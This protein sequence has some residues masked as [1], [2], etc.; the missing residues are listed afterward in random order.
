MNFKVGDKVHDVYDYRNYV[1]KAVTDKYIELIN[2]RC[3]SGKST[4]DFSRL[5]HGHLDHENFDFVTEVKVKATPKPKPKK[6]HVEFS[7]DHA[8]VMVTK[9]KFESIP[10]FLAAWA[11]NDIEVNL[12]V[13]SNTCLGTTVYTYTRNGNDKLTN[14]KLLKD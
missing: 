2:V 10:Q 4:L 11:Q 13:L 6:Y 12:G 9:E 8:I 5:R 7:V 3:G 1:V 14:V